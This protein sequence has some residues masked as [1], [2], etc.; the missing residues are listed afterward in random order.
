MLGHCREA[1]EPTASQQVPLHSSLVIPPPSPSSSCSSFSRLPHATSCFAQVTLDASI[2]GYPALIGLDDFS[3]VWLLFVFHD[4]TNAT[5]NGVV[6]EKPS[7]GTSVGRD[8]EGESA[9]LEGRGTR[10]EWA[11][12]AGEKE[13]AERWGGG[14][15]EY[16]Q[17]RHKLRQTFLTKVW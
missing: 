13:R 14:A 12:G 4:N 11:L 5:V 1:G 15:R 6:E 3:H 7:E 10:E 8:A 17:P 16:Q 9:A 2:V